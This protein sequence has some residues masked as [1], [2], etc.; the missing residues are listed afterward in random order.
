MG[1]LLP[2]K[3]VLPFSSLASVKPQDSLL[4]NSDQAPRWTASIFILQDLLPSG[5]TPMEVKLDSCLQVSG[6]LKLN[7]STPKFIM[8]PL[9]A[10]LSLSS[11]DVTDLLVPDLGTTKKFKNKTVRLEDI[12]INAC[13]T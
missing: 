8:S 2:K 11:L 3:D 13:F 5:I 9:E 4:L 7:L 1:Q 12:T 6:Y 10:R